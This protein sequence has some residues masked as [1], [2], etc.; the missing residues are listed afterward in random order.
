MADVSEN[1]GSWWDQVR[2]FVQGIY[3][4][5]LKSTP[6]ER[7]QLRSDGAEHLAEGKW[8]RLNARVC[9]LLMASMDESIK[10]D[11]IARQ[12]TRSATVMLLRLF[13]LYQPGGAAERT[14]VLTRLQSPTEGMTFAQSLEAIRTWPRWLRRC[15]EM[16]MSVPDGTVLAKAL[17]NIVEPHVKSDQDV[18]FRMQLVR[19]SLRVD[20]QPT[21]EQVR[22]YQEHLQSEMEH[23]G[24][25]SG[26]TSPS[27][28]VRAV[29]G[30]AAKD[31]VEASSQEASKGD[32][33][34]FLK[35]S[36]CWRG[37][38][39]PFRHDMSSLSKQQ[40]ARK[41][42][43]CGSEE[44]RQKECPTKSSSPT[45]ARPPGS[46]S[47][48]QNDKSQRPL[49]SAVAVS[50]SAQR[51]ETLGSSGVSSEMGTAEAS[52]G[53]PVATL[54]H[55]LQVAAQVLQ[56]GA[57]T[58]AVSATAELKVLRVTGIARTSCGGEGEGPMALL[59]SGATHALRAAETEAEWLESELVKVTLAGGKSVN[60]RMNA[61]STLLFP[62]KPE[63]EV[64]SEMPIIPMG[65]LAQ[66]LGYTMEWA[67]R[68]C[69]LVGRDGETIQLKVRQNC[70]VLT[71]SQ[72]LS[73]IS[74]LEDVKLKGLEE[75]TKETKNRVRAAALRL[76]EDWFQ[77]MMRFMKSGKA[78]DGK[79]SIAESSHFKGIP[80]ESLD[81][82][83][84]DFHEFT[85][86]ELLKKLGCWNR[87][88]R[89]ALMKSKSIIVHLFSG[90]QEKEALRHLEK[91]GKGHFVMSVDLLAGMDVRN[92]TVWALLLKLASSGRVAA[93][94]GGPP[95][96]TFSILRFRP[97]GPRPVRSR[98]QPYGLD[99]LDGEERRLVDQDT[100]HFC[101]FI[102]LHSAATAGRVL[103]EEVE[104]KEVAFFVEQPADP[105]KYLNA[106]N[107]LYGKVPTFWQTPLWRRYSEEAQLWVVTFD[108][109][110]LGHPTVKPTEGGTNL[111]GAR[112]L[113]GIQAAERPPPWT[114]PSSDL[115]TWSSGL[116]EVIAEGIRNWSGNPRIFKMTEEQWKAHVSRGHVPY[117]RECGASRLLCP[118]SRHLWAFEDAGQGLTPARG[119]TS[120]EVHVR[121]QV[122][123]AKGLSSNGGVSDEGIFNRRGGH[124][125]GGESRSS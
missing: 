48:V 104:S 116:C 57:P 63:N 107:P 56:A 55:M 102:F 87:S 98:E 24:T 66:T 47:I 105:D 78:E 100:G 5:W 21:L 20:G 8:S 10:K 36:G 89:K 70:P 44:H 124:R 68:K 14:T 76:E 33:R 61:A 42:L 91:E 77:K 15:E 18:M 34:F 86:W 7:V 30:P 53:K 119:Q 109:L 81:G 108:Q 25:S 93:V 111:E 6:L 62:P 114:G 92:E 118:Y 117:R 72:A 28:K 43:A 4:K 85:E 115:A 59:D 67:G 97:P 16:K 60:M 79:T 106:D 12:A 1:S 32:C 99:D 58:T 3:S 125:R 26:A 73:L 29:S 40:R 11:L 122:E 2:D 65:E 83:A 13:I 101:R 74:R 9:T 95:C 17:T 37:V 94:I 120:Y 39:C 121:G 50:P 113:D 51:L 45:R 54:E 27:M 49:G 22:K 46:E 123:G 75:K 64:S 112:C 82:I 71:E 35:A 41:C 19:S 52:P 90:K 84:T 88:R 110:P 23:L 103:N 38:K 96:R 69:K 31:Y 80:V